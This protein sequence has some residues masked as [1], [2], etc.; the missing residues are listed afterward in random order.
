[1]KII[2]NKELELKSV[3]VYLKIKR[4]VQ[5][6]EIKEYLDS[7]GEL[8]TNKIVAEG[9]KRYLKGKNYDNEG[10]IEEYEEG[11]Y[12]IWYTTKDNSN[13][14]GD[15]IFYFKRLI[16][17]EFH[18]QTLQ[19]LGINF[20]N[21][22][23]HLLTLKNDN[24]D[25]EIVS[26]FEVEGNTNQYIGETIKSE[27]IN[28]VWTWEDIESTN[29][30][31]FGKL[32]IAD[33]N[34]KFEEIDCKKIYDSKIYKVELDD[35]I[36][37][38][39]ENWDK[40]EKR[41]SIKLDD[42]KR[43]D[44]NYNKFLFTSDDD[45]KCKYYD[46]PVEPWDQDEAIEWRKRIINSELEKEYMHPDD[47]NDYII[48]VNQNKG[49]NKY[50]PHLDNNIPKLD[51]YLQKLDSKNKSARGLEYWHLAAPKDLN[52]SIEKKRNAPY[53]K[54]YFILKEKEKKCL[55]DLTDEFVS[56]NEE[57]T[58][59]RIFY[60]DRYV[61]N[62]Y[63]QRTVS[64]FLKNFDA[65]AVCIITDTDKRKFNEYLTREKQE[66][67][68]EDINKIFKKNIPH[69]R[70]LI[71]KKGGNIEVWTS[72]NSMDYI[73]FNKNGEIDCVKD[74]GIIISGVTYIKVTIDLL[75]QE[76]KNFVLSN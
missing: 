27:I 66:I 34:S 46:I 8:F 67:F 10:N 51:E 43:D 41:K 17:V 44:F 20:N 11:K 42:I 26:E 23:Y 52:I 58:Y 13:L 16:P 74:E 4:K 53:C 40:A 29:F 68:I 33:K 59:D 70:Y 73:R 22:K 64:C 47:F 12:Q 71:F 19:N 28:Y 38:I 61:Y 54:E 5:R 36:T 62:Y 39:I 60:Y 56:L 30:T 75:G 76:L 55:K 35:Y 25:Y 14:F 63:Q 21:K 7:N 15:R 31:F 1:M 69:D 37:K 3:I 50:K 2:I 9:V 72:T 65:S 57:K 49:F 48:S 45:S 24:N 32:N 18:N 6:K